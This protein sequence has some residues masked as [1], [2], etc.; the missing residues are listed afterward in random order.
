MIS[1][2]DEDLVGEPRHRG[3]LGPVAPAHDR[4][5][6]PG[7]PEGEVLQAQDLVDDRLRRAATHSVQPIFAAR[8][9]A[10]PSPISE[11]RTPSGAR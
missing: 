7:R 5:A 1:L 4:T 11:Y 3:V 9:L 6:G 10:A 2:A 8:G